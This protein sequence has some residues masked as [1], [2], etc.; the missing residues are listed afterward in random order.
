[1]QLRLSLP[2]MALIMAANTQAEDYVTFQYL[3]YQENDNRVSVSAPSVMINKDFGTDFTLNASFVADA[4]SGASPTYYAADTVSSASATTVDSASGASAYSRGKNIAA[5]RVKYG[6]VSFFEQRAAGSVMLTSRFANRD[7][8]IVSGDFSSEHDFESISGAAEY[9]HWLTPAK[10]QSLSLGVSFQS[11]EIVARCVDE[12]NCD[13]SSGASQEKQATAVNA[14][15]SFMQNINRTSYIK[16]AL[17]YIADDGY[18]TDPYL[19]VVRNNNGVTADV[20]GEKRPEKR[21]GYGG[22]VRYANALT[23][24]LTLQVGYRYYQ[25]DWEVRSH[26]A[27]TD[28]FY[29]LTHSW[30]FNLGLRGYTQSAA[31]FYNGTSNYFTDELYA[32]SDYRM[33]D[34]HAVTYKADVR[35]AF[36]KAFSVNLGG[37]YYDQSTG[38]K[39]VSLLTG[40]R[41]NF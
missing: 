12:V 29:D 14:Q 5:D 2:A 40:F 16:A 18:L 38:L 27:D 36:T 37:N 15:I 41:Y 11:N 3:Q 33:S 24:D 30:R 6:N 32:T 1:M 20:V 26:T 13:A 19:N 4:V 7:E 25:D 35:Y 8:L 34:F 10:N 39:A 31:S 17:F 9:M 28:L 21:R 22:T 23:D